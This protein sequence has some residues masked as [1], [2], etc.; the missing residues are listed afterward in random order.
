M[1]DIINGWRKTLIISP[2]N[3]NAHE[4]DGDK[5]IY[6][7]HILN[8]THTN[9]IISSTQNYI[10]PSLYRIVLSVQ[11][12]QLPNNMAWTQFIKRKFLHSKLPFSYK[13]TTRPT[14]F[15]LSLLLYSASASSSLFCGVVPR[16]LV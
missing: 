15:S 16:G 11:Q 13:M 14:L 8:T 2:P 3:V 10:D 6:P 9:T 5:K 4:D 12:Q 7:S 1:V